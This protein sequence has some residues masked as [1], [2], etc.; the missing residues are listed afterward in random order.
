M[1][2]TLKHLNSALKKGTSLSGPM[3][4]LSI[5]GA[6]ILMVALSA[7]RLFAQSSAEQVKITYHEP[8][9][10]ETSREARDLLK[11]IYDYSGKHVLSGQHNYIGHQSKHSEETLDLTGEFP[12]V[13]GSDFGFSDSTNDKDGVHYRDEMVDE[14]KKM[15]E[16]GAVITLMWH[17]CRPVDE[18]PCTWTGSVQNEVSEDEWEDLVTPGTE[19]HE[20]WANQVDEI[21]AYLQQIE[22]ANIPVLWRPYHEMNGDWFWWGKKK[23]ENGYTKLWKML[24][25]RLTHYH[26]INNLLWVWNPNAP[27]YADDYKPYYPGDE[28]VDILAADIYRNDYQKEF[29]DRLLALGDGKPI[30]MGE[31]GE[32]PTAEILQEQ[33]YWVWFMAWSNSNYNRNDPQKVVKL[34]KAEK[35]IGLEE[36][37]KLNHEKF[38]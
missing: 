24:Y 11:M 9:N 38:K 16:K 17:A 3:Y 13:W 14:I 22:N 26:D 32:V 19:I 4:K 31:V 37:K 15:H 29:H 34:Y 6:I 21:A 35:V 8:V 5:L 10:P 12:V 27:N 18:E 20:N 7:N 23:G 25:K 30:A 33:P 1:N 36:F 28:Y 2:A